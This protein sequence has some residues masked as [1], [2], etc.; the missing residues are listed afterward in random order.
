MAK[1]L[2]QFLLVRL[3]RR[4]LLWRP[5]TQVADEVNLYRPIQIFVFGLRPRFAVFWIM[6]RDREMWTIRTPVV[7]IS[8]ENF[9]NLPA[10]VRLSIASCAGENYGNR[11]SSRLT[12]AVEDFILRGMFKLDWHNTLTA[13]RSLNRLVIHIIVTGHWP[14][15]TQK[16]NP[17]HF[18]WYFRKPLLAT[19]TP[20]GACSTQHRDASSN[21]RHQFSFLQDHN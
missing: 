11:V 4:T 12:E 7:V 1:L 19:N 10:Q 18:R 21:Q 16:F 6:K 20:L 13:S 9:P 15:V 5:S 14:V 17:T 3:P 2:K 8:L